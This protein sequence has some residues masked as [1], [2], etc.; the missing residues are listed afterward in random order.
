VEDA[1]I[2]ELY[3]TGNYGSYGELHTGLVCAGDPEV[4]K[5]KYSLLRFDLTTCTGTIGNRIWTD[6][7]VT[8]ASTNC[9]GLQDAGEPGINGVTVQLKNSSG[10]VIQTVVTSGDGGYLFTNVCAGE[11]TVVVD[12]STLPSGYTATMC[13]DAVGVDNNSN[14]TGYVELVT[15]GQTDLTIDFGYCPSGCTAS[16]GNVVWE[17]KTGDLMYEPGFDKPI[18]GVKVTLNLGLPGEKSVLTDAAGMYYFNGLC[19]GTYTVTVDLTTV[20]FGISPL[21]PCDDALKQD[22]NSNCN[23]VATTLVAGEQN[24]TIDFG[25]GGTPYCGPCPDPVGMLFKSIDQYGDLVVT[26]AQYGVNDNTYGTGS[27]WGHKFGDLVGSDKAE[28][29]FK[30]ASGNVVLDF[31]CD[32]ISGPGYPTPSGYK[33]LGATGGD[34]SMV[35]GNAAWIKN[36]TTSLDDNLN[37][38]GYVLLVN[39]PAVGDP[40]YPHWNNINSYTVTIDKAAFGGNA[41]SAIVAIGYV[42]D[43]PPHCAPNNR[44]EPVPCVGGPPSPCNLSTSVAPI[45]DRLVKVNITNNGTS[46]F[47]LSRVAINWPSENGKLKKIKLDGDVLYDVV[48]APPSVD[49]THFKPS[50]PSKYTVKAGETDQLIFEFERNADGSGYIIDVESASGCKFQVLK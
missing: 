49:V 26:Y 10:V 15:D 46:P 8:G 21:M 27:D 25:F 31:L 16:I 13:N 42:H 45:K 32:Y 30:N 19:A 41:S 33:C 2:T 9:N 34:G 36:A 50:D 5:E 38:W 20:P 22:N 48:T 43:S 37:K 12:A 1:F 44:I 4:C 39:S 24:W 3:P 47:V 29:I 18:E 17:E 40:A 23:G 11:Y 35:S 7:S 14:C 6:F 28:F